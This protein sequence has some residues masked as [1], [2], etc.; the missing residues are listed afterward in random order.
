M[1]NII[2]TT[3]NKA[4]RNR[5]ALRLSKLTGRAIDWRSA[6]CDCDEWVFCS[7]CDGRGGYHEAFFLSCSHRVFDADDLECDGCAEREAKREA[8]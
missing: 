6:D 4:E 1:E 3:A 7:R 2:T 8:A 5:E